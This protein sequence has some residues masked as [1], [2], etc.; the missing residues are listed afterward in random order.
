MFLNDMRKLQARIERLEHEDPFEEDQIKVLLDFN[1][2]SEKS[3]DKIYLL[4]M[5]PLKKDWVIKY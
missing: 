5:V 3:P 1:R 2:D 4:A